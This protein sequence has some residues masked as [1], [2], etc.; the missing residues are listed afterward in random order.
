MRRMSVIESSLLAACIVIIAAVI[1]ILVNPARQIAQA[2]NDKRQQDV[3]LIASALAEYSLDH[4]ESF[5]AFFSA[6]STRGI[7]RSSEV[8]ISCRNGIDISELIRESY[9]QAVPVDP[10]VEVDAAETGYVVQKMTDSR[11]FIVAAP[12]A[13]LGETIEAR[14]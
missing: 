2:N 13:E 1:I 8:D 14:R 3:E 4:S 10:S 6:S 12:H 5:P 7:C 9:I 11:H